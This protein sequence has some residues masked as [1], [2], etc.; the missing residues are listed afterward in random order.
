MERWKPVSEY[1]GLYEV[2]DLGRVRTIKSGWIKTQTMNKRDRRLY[3]LL[4]K[5]NIYQLFKV[6]RLVLFTFVGL[7]PRGHEACHND[8][9]PHNNKLD[10]LRWDTP[11]NNQADRV[12]H[13][14][15]NRGEQCGTSKLTQTEVKA[16]RADTRKQKY[17]AAE[18]G[19]QQS[20]VSRIKNLKRWHY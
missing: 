11:A 3:M 1:E 10:N 8:G 19:I 17:I 2:S 16:I 15:S 12:K 14:T 20:Q 18:Y 6:H 4:W 7:P 9:D 5:N 13:G